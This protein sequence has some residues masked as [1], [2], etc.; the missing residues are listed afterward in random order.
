MKIRLSDISPK[1]L[2]V[3]EELP[4]DALNMRMNEG[5]PGGIE[6][7]KAP[8]VNITVIGTVSGAELKGTITTSYRQP[9]A[10]CLEQRD[11]TLSL[12]T[13]CLLKPRSEEF[14]EEDDIGI[15]FFE[16]EHV[17]LDSFFQEEIILA[18]TLYWHPE[19][20]ARGKCTEC[21]R[22]A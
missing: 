19:F 10:L 3:T 12:Q 18:L 6:F 21:K 15:I 11:R 9:C 14:K 7:T 2:Q 17:E 5:K 16:G 20:D 13:R 22:V 8:L 4:L 1:G